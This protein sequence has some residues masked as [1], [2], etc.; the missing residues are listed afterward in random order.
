M[1]KVE[2]FELRPSS[3]QSDS[4]RIT[5]LI[6]PLIHYLE[7]NT[8]F[9]LEK[10]IEEFGKANAKYNAELQKEEIERV[11]KLKRADAE[12]RRKEIKLAGL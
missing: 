11:E 7:T 9:S 1:R 10:A 12:T 2:L 8:K 6:Q 5:C 3:I 4:R